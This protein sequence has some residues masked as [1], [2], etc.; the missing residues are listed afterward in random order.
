LKAAFRL[1]LALTL[2]PVVLG[3]LG[4]VLSWALSCSGMEHIETCAVSGAQRI[5]A[6]L[7]AFVTVSVF[8]VPVGCI[9][10]AVLGL[11]QAM[12]NARKRRA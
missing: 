11:V 4:M 6:P 7:I 8:V 12:R 5:V 9:A 3:L 1:A 2:L 10:L